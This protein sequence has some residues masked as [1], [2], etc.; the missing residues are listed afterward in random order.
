MGRGYSVRAL[1]ALAMF[2]LTVD[3]IGVD[4]TS[5]ARALA[6]ADAA[7][8]LMLA[9]LPP[10]EIAVITGPSGAGKSTLLNA[11]ER[12]RIDSATRRPERIVRID[13]GR[14]PAPASPH[15]RVIDAIARSSTAANAHPARALRLLASCG[16]G[17]IR[18]ALSPIQHLSDGERA[19]LSLA[20]ALAACEHTGDART[21][22]LADEFAASLDDL[23]ACALAAAIARRVRSSRHLR[24]VV[25]THRPALLGVIRPAVIVRVRGAWLAPSPA[26]A[27]RAG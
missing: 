22:L 2:G 21:L 20:L 9:A 15:V 5:R 27:R 13:A 23:G 24:A 1:R 26:K 6:R 18:L 7:A 12:D 8:R 11:L 17:D 19:R 10:G 14:L 16:L 25:V 4:A 3:D